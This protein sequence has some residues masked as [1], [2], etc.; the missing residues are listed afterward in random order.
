MT[1]FSFKA[2]DD[3]MFQTEERNRSLVIQVL[4]FVEEHSIAPNAA[5][6][7]DKD[8]HVYETAFSDTSLHEFPHEIIQSNLPALEKIG[9]H[10]WENDQETIE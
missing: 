3:R 6:S 10:K 4:P 1:F 8:I 9:R 5:D 7:T 2:Y